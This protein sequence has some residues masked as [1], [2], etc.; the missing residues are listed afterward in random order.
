MGLLGLILVGAEY[1]ATGQQAGGRAHYGE[2]APE[3]ESEFFAPLSENDNSL[4]KPRRDSQYNND[5]RCDLNAAQEKP[6]TAW[7][8][9]GP[10]ARIPSRPGT[11]TSESNYSQNYNR[12]DYDTGAGMAQGDFSEVGMASWYGREFDGKKTAS[13]QIFDS[14]RLTAAHRTLP[15]GSVVKVRNMDNGKEVTVTINDRGP[16]VQG[17][18]L[19]ISEQGA[20][21]LEF[22][23][24][25]LANVGLKILQS[26]SGRSGGPV[27]ENGDGA[28]NGAETAYVEPGPETSASRSDS[29]V[30]GG[31]DEDGYYQ[32]TGRSAGSTETRYS[33]Y[34]DT[35]GTAEKIP[36]SGSK[37][38]AGKFAIQAGVF[39]SSF[40]ANSF[41]ETLLTYG[42]PVRV[43]RRGAQF[44]VMIEGFR[45][46]RAADAVNRRLK[47]NGYNSFVTR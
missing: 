38:A 10:A 1:C 6:Q 3:E 31:R 42:Q 16:Y 26:G 4:R 32:S 24:R 44:V 45:D 23:Q 2:D 36:E 19:D 17:R 25:G 40:N 29:G 11:P 9:E 43:V 46:R 7:N 35:M 30:G 12:E 47:E 14:R 5:C 27:S 8:Q 33:D 18:I 20:E 28:E 22:K 41:K 34:D 37:P 13:G 39:T 15:L 21:L